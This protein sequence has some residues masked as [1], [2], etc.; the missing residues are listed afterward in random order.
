MRLFHSGLGAIVAWNELVA[1]C[2]DAD[3]VTADRRLPSG[4][5]PRWLKLDR[6]MLR[7]TGGMA[8]TLP[9]K[10]RVQT[11]A[12]WVGKHPWGTFDEQPRFSSG[13]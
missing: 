2:A 10:P 11:A 13:G 9:A 7:R 1:A 5:A 8:I 3:I 12:Q 4:C 6:V